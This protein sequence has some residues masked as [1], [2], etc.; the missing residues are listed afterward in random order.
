MKKVLLMPFSLLCVLLLAAPVFAMENE[1]DEFLGVPWGAV[2]PEKNFIDSG[3]MGGF[4]ALR[5]DPVGS[6]I[7][8]QRP[9]E[10][11]RFAGVKPLS[12]IAYFFHDSLGFVRA[13]MRFKGVKNYERML[14]ACVDQ[15]GK[16][17]EARRDDNQKL[18]YDLASNIWKGERI[19]V[20]LHYYYKRSEVGVLALYL[21]SYLEETRKKEDAEQ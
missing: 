11:V 14:A 4:K 13:H 19:T 18:D 9:G 21:N 1:P 3:D 17:D 8:Y 5:V 20:S 7:V 2:S 12:P 6:V 10:K 15:W 16:P